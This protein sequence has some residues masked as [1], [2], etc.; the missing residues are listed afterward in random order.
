MINTLWNHQFPLPLLQ[1]KVTALPME[2]VGVGS[3]VGGHGAEV[4]PRVEVKCHLLATYIYGGGGH[5]ALSI[6]SKGVYI[7]SGNILLLFLPPPPTPP[8]VHRHPP[9]TT[10]VPHQDRPPPSTESWCQSHSMKW[11]SCQVFCQS[12][13]PIA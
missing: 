4:E 7:G 1:A 8:S 12:A 5:G 2:A 3:K 9:P 6:S 11:P 10:Q 13:S